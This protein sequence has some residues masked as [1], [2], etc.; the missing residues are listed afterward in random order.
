MQHCL[1]GG[2]N[3]PRVTAHESIGAHL[4]GDR[5]LGIGPHGDARDTEDGGFFLNPTAIGE[6]HAR[7]GDQA[8][9]R[10]IA[11]GFDQ[12]QI[13]VIRAAF[14]L[15]GGSWVDRKDDR[16]AV[17]DLTNGAHDG[18]ESFRA[19][20]IPGAM[21]SEDR[22]PALRHAGSERQLARGAD[23][24]QQ[25]IDH[26]VADKGNPGG[27]HSFAEQI[28]I[29]A[30]VGGEEQVGNGIGT[31]AID[32]FWHG[33]IPGAQPSLDMSYAN[34]QFAC[35]ESA[36]DGGIDIAHNDDPIRLVLDADG[37]EFNHDASGLLRMRARANSE[38]D[39]RLWNL[40]VGE[41]VIGH[42]GVIVLA[43]VNQE[44][45]VVTPSAE[46]FEDGRDFHKI[47]ARAGDQHEFHMD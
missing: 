11:Q 7:I 42:L 18:F 16:D 31:E 34:A 29:G 24:A 20:H 47:G 33:H 12:V 21:E 30:A 15:L 8:E 40:K 5:A 41:E 25:G 17:R 46:G 2:P 38:I 44:D 9:E 3:A 39:V 13:G 1:S 32:F 37:L 4:T 26:G 28:P 43:R 35:G 14:E 45:V 36:G 10:E 19:I 23:V 6:D 27:R 22:I